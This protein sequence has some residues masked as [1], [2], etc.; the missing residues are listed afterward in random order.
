MLSRVVG[1]ALKAQERHSGVTGLRKLVGIC[2]SLERSKRD[3]GNNCKRCLDGFQLNLRIHVLIKR[4][5][6]ASLVSFTSLEFLSYFVQR[7]A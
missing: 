1:P 7:L 3:T 2:N 4:E 6:R 5:E